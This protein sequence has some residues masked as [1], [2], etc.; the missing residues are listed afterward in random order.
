[1]ISNRRFF[2]LLARANNL[3]SL[4]LKPRFGVRRIFE[5]RLPFHLRNE[6]APSSRSDR[7][8]RRSSS[9]SLEGYSMR[10]FSSRVHAHRTL[11]RHL[12]HRRPGRFALARGPNGAEAARRAQCINNLKQIG[13]ALHNYTT[14]Y[15]VLPFG[16][17]GSYAQSVPGTP[18]YARWS[19]NSQVLMFL[20]Q[21]NLFNAINFN[22]PPET[23]GMAG[24]V[25]FMPA[26]QNPDRS[27]MTWSRL[28]VATFLCP[29]DPEGALDWEGNNSYYGNQQTWACD[30][31]ESNPSTLAPGE[32][33]QGIF[34]FGSFVKPAN[35]TDG[36]SQTAFYSEKLKGMG[37]P[38]PR[39]DMLNIP[40]QSSLT[41]T[42]LTCQAISPATAVP[43]TSKQGA[44]W[45]MGEMCC[46]TYNHVAT[47]NSHTCSGVGFP[48]SMA[49]MAMQVPPSSQ[50]PG[51]V[52]L[53]MGDGSVHFV[54]NGIDLVTWRGLGTRNGGEV[55]N[56]DF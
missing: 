28:K 19:A 34:Y 9:V 46:T 26:F 43:L 21:G 7:I 3:A 10:S 51:G 47:P 24:A 48:G 53:L 52:N 17:G 37:T 36:M 54:K 33:N 8:V 20:E 15:G 40:N 35:I 27:N 22:L 1:M 31:S 16:K 45:V 29:S 23:P 2:I 39:T 18:V 6:I 38:N 55:I 13:V 12:H 4:D 41:A 50:H 5:E 42:Y 32:K 11:G 30:L 25:P 14:T 44:S 56:I 49:N